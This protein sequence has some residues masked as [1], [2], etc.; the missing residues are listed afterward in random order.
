MLDVLVFQ[1]RGVETLA[2]HPKTDVDQVEAGHSSDIEGKDFVLLLLVARSTCFHHF[3]DF[4]DRV[5]SPHGKGLFDVV[6]VEELLDRGRVAL[7]TDQLFDLAEVG[8]EV[9]RLFAL[10]NLPGVLED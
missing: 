2:C 7:K 3:A 6:N 5:D 9:V 8:K 1:L 4:F 10:G